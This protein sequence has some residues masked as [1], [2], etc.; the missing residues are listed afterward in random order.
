LKSKQTFLAVNLTF[1]I[2]IFS[3]L[4]QVYDG[5]NGTDSFN[6]TKTCPVAFPHK[7]FTPNEG[8]EDPYCSSDPLI[9]Q[10]LASAE[11]SIMVIV[12]GVIGCCVVLGL[13]LSVFG[14]QWRQRARAK[15]N[16]AKMTM[17][18]TGYED[19]EPLRPTNIKPNLAKLKI[20]REVELRK[21][22]V[23]GFGAFGTVYR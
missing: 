16:T 8:H 23:L 6:C 7:V 22:S 18:M 15:E 17:V 21:G 1:I 3:L 2:N 5:H 14:Y 13:F 9:G 11:N 19:N 20:V 10:K 4:F 12:G